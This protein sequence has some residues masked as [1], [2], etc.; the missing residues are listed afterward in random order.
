[1]FRTICLHVYSINATEA[2]GEIPFGESSDILEEF[3]LTEMACAPAIKYLIQLYM[4]QVL[5]NQKCCVPS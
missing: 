4:C 3:L 1:M 2:V 5:L